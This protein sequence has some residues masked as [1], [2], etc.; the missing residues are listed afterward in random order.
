MGMEREISV[1]LSP[2]GK[3]EPD[4]GEGSS[5]KLRGNTH[6]KP[7]PTWTSGSKKLT[8]PCDLRQSCIGEKAALLSFR[9]DSH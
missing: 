4:I 2:V 5:L 7:N 9:K 1:F 8:H 3:M 6:K